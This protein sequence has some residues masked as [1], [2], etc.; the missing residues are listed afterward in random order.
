MDDSQR[1]LNPDELGHVVLRLLRHAAKVEGMSHIEGTWNGAPFI[2]MAATGA[3]VGLVKQ[4]T[5]T[6]GLILVSNTTP[7]GDDGA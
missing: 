2:L 4:Y 3:N 7:E 6:G 5:R 1:K